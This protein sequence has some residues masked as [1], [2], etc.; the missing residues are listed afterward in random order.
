MHDCMQ[1][2]IHAFSS[3]RDAIKTVIPAYPV[4]GYKKRRFVTAFSK[5]Y[6]VSSALNWSYS[7]NTAGT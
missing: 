6:K 7:F 3:T 5:I 1:S 2:C 4:G